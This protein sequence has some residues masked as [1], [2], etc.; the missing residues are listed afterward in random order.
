MDGPLAHVRVLELANK[1]PVAQCCSML[2][3]LGADV[4]RVDRVRSGEGNDSERDW[5]RG[6]RSVLIDLRSESGRAAVRRM[7]KVADVMVEGFRPGTA[8]QMGLDAEACMRENPRLVVGRMSGWG[9]SGDMA[10]MAGHDINFIGA[11]GAL[12]AIGRRNEAPAIPLNLLGDGAGGLLLAFGIAAALVE[13]EASGRGQVVDASMVDAA[14]ALMIRIYAGYANGSWSDERGTN[15]IDSGAP[16]YDVYETS[17]GAYVAVGAIEA[18][19][20][21]RLLAGLNISRESFGDQWDRER[22]ELQREMLT[23]A[24][25]Q[26]SRDEWCDIFATIDACVSPV[27]ALNEAAQHPL[28][29]SRRAFVRANGGWTPGAVPEFGRSG[30]KVRYMQAAPG[31]HTNEA[32]ADWGFSQSDI[33]ALRASGAAR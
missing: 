22:W 26:R 6:R 23:A 9:R 7:A 4:L 16:F 3:D 12:H 19:F 33:A 5:R 2:G 31:Q 28:N 10:A 13:R 24:F 14:S 15:Y 20:F 17:D 27:L 8:E 11:S 25:R 18:K 1:G 30:V 21:A 32:L 29:A